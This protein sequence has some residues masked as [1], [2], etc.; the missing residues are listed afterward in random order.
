MMMKS[1]ISI[2][3]IGVIQMSV[4]AYYALFAPIR[5]AEN[6]SSYTICAKSKAEERVRA[7]YPAILLEKNMETMLV[8]EMREAN[9]LSHLAKEGW[10]SLHITSLFL[11]F[12]GFFTLIAGIRTLKPEQHS[13]ETKH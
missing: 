6:I 8:D 7:K 13:S 5:V 4:G 12:G 9:G 2:I 11:A 1:A 10:Q 3:I